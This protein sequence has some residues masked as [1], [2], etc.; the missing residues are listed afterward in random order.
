[1][2]KF[3]TIAILL[4]ALAGSSFGQTPSMHCSKPE[5]DWTTVCV[6]DDGTVNVTSA[7]PDGTYSSEWFSKE[8]WYRYSN[9]IIFEP[10][11]EER[12][13]LATA[14]LCKRGDFNKDYCDAFW[15]KHR[16]AQKRWEC[17]LATWNPT[18]DF[19]EL[20]CSAFTQSTTLVSSANSSVYGQV[21]TFTVKVT[22]TRWDS[23]IPTGSVDFKD[24]TA[25]LQTVPVSSGVASLL[26]STLAPGVHTIMAFYS[27]DPN[28]DGGVSNSVTQ[29]ITAG[30]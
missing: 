24:G 21:V 28:F 19:P 23:G 20:S 9:H 8:E 12:S 3:I 17:L 13:I 16:V 30:K 11:T 5:N 6:F 15:P 25:L 10:V 1:M 22:Q 2:K 29:M 27:G 18:P 7:P 14:K 4:L 26:T